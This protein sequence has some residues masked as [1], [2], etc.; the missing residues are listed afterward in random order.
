MA[1]GSTGVKK[2][3]CSPIV[4]Y[5]KREVCKCY[6]FLSIT[7]QAVC[8]LAA[9][10]RFHWRQSSWFKIRKKEIYIHSLCCQ[11]SA[12]YLFWLNDF[13]LWPENIIIK[14]QQ[15]KIDNNGLHL[16]LCEVSAGVALSMTNTSVS[17]CAYESAKVSLRP[18]IVCPNRCPDF[19]LIWLEVVISH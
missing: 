9:S 14:K 15:S 6:M 19:G 2:F 1:T 17:G 8:S 13:L 5:Y 3:P 11:F 7:V 10:V 16:T 12:V 18:E 4:H